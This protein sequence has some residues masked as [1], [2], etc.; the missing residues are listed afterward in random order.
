[1]GVEVKGH[2]TRYRH[3]TGRLKPLTTV[4]PCPSAGTTTTNQPDSTEVPRGQLVV[5]LALQMLAAQ[6]LQ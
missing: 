2:T 1:M 6:C 5:L 4:R 3:N